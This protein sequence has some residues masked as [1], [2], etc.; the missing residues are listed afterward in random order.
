MPC[1]SVRLRSLEGALSASVETVDGTILRNVC[2]TERLLWQGC[3]SVF[4]SLADG[5][6]CL[7]GVIAG[8]STDL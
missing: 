7:R 6:Q 8:D 4:L 3:R 5:V 2:G 1:G